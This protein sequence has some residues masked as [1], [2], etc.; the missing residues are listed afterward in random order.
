MIKLY[1]MLSLIY[2]FISAEALSLIYKFK[3]CPT[4]GKIS[5]DIVAIMYKYDLQKLQYTNMKIA[6]FK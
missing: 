2:K 6:H 3:I 4:A 1:C 5:T